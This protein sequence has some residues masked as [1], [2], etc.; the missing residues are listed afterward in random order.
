MMNVEE[1]NIYIDSTSIIDEGAKIGRNCK[2]WQ[3]VHICSGA[4]IGSNCSFGQNVFISGKVSVGNN[5]KIQNNVSIYDGLIIEE[6]VFIGPSVVFTNVKVPRAEIDQKKLYSQ[7]IIKAGCTIGANS[8]IVCGITLNE[9]C[10][11]AA[12]AV[13]TKDVDPYALMSGVP[14]RKIGT[15]NKDGNKL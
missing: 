5:V 4:K 13:V 7:T 8:T 14:A 11:I 1:Q 12:G 9:Y 15:V 3:W 6:N 2:I 10:F